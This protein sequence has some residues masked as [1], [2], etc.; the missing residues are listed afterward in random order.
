MYTQYAHHYLPAQ[1]LILCTTCVSALA[2]ARSGALTQ[3]DLSLR[4]VGP[5]RLTLTGRQPS[6]PRTPH[7]PH[8]HSSHHIN[9]R[10]VA[11][12][13]AYAPQLHS[14]TSS[15]S[16]VL[17]KVYHQ[18]IDTSYHRTTEAY[19][20]RI[21]S[22]HQCAWHV[23]PWPHAQSHTPDLHHMQAAAHTCHPSKDRALVASSVADKLCSHVPTPW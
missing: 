4:P 20:H 9:C 7:P 16:S 19:D 17:L 1:P 11:Y 6:P 10:H 12:L 2:A 3:G 13:D 18:A 5:H 22:K 15:S 8:L 21:K 14:S 23:L